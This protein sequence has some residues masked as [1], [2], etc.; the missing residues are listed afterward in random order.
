MKRSRH[1]A[2]KSR[3]R[4]ELTNGHRNYII[5]DSPFSDW[6]HRLDHFFDHPPLQDHE[7]A[8]G[9][10]DETPRKVRHR[11]R[12]A[13]ICAKRRWQTILGILDDGTEDALR[14]NFR[15]G[16]GWRNPYTLGTCVFVL[17]RSR[18]CR[19]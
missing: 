2:W 19:G 1:S 18:R 9:P 4:R 16:A 7:I 15:R 6:V 3:T 10:A 14:E 11:S 5:P 12:I 8:G 17:A 13:R